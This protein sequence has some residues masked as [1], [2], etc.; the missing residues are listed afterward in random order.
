MGKEFLMKTTQA[1]KNRRKIE[2]YTYVFIVD[3]LRDRAKKHLDG[4]AVR[5]EV[6]ELL[7][8]MVP[9]NHIRH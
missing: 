7:S 8:S 2:D 5:R 1:C 4:D 6:G 3:L 9:T